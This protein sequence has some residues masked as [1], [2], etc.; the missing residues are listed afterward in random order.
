MGVETKERGTKG[1]C[2]PQGKIINLLAQRKYRTTEQSAP[3]AYDRE[4][5]LFDESWPPRDFH[6]LGAFRGAQ[7]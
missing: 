4:L 3:S 7:S 6:V 5:L 2:H 1:A